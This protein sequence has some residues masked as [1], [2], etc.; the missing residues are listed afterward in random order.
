MNGKVLRAYLEPAWHNKEKEN[1]EKKVIVNKSHSLAAVFASQNGI[2]HFMCKILP[3]NTMEGHLRHFKQAFWYL[4]NI[5]KATFYKM[6]SGGHL[7]YQCGPKSILKT[8]QS[9]KT[10]IESNLDL[11]CPQFFL[12]I[13]RV[14]R[15]Q[16]NA[17][18]PMRISLATIKEKRKL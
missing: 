13:A 7:I 12:K 6:A 3:I 8:V 18:N 2:N 17:T 16:M 4:L 1:V 5:G 11:K 10:I 9:L 15:R 14:F